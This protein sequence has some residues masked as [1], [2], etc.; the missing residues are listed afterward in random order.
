MPGSAKIICLFILLVLA[1]GSNLLFTK[2]GSD[3]EGSPV[4]TI[5]LGTETPSI[6]AKTRGFGLYSPDSLQEAP[7]M[8]MSLGLLLPLACIGMIVY[9]LVRLDSKPTEL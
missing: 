6:T 9:I 7:W 5:R 3:L 2:W 8:S 4:L 1:I